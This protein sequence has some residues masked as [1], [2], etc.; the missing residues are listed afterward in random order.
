MINQ[1][2]DLEHRRPDLVQ[3]S[4]AMKAKGKIRQSEMY[5][6]TDCPGA[7]SFSNEVPV[8]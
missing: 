2:G 5:S 1:C 7:I 6:H 8:K 3:G 4:I